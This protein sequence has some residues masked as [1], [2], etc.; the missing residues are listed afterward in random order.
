MHIGQDTIFYL[1]KGYRVVA[2][3]ANPKLVQE[4]GLRFA[5]YIDSGQLIL[6]NKGVS[7]VSGASMPFYV[8]KAYS[9]WSS[10]VEEIGARGGDYEIIEVDVVPILS[11]FDLYGCP[12]YLKIDIEGLDFEVIKSL[13]HS[14]ELPRYISAENG[15]DF[16]IRE[17]A[18]LGYSSFKFINQAQIGGRQAKKPSLEGK[19]IDFVFEHGASGEFG[20]DTPGE[21]KEI[22]Q[23]LE[24]S[25]AYWSNPSRDANIDGWYD[26]HAKLY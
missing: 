24:L 21:W 16:M 2:V 17:L 4:A 8:N 25:N 14:S 1:D 15:Q 19:T 23:V 12:Y 22:N 20:E 26:I 13:H 5:S 7:G 6:L 18:A 3:E 11:I 10:F 9:E